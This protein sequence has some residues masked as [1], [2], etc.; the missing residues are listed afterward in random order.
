[1]KTLLS[2]LLAFSLA[3]VASAN[4]FI[5]DPITGKLV[6]VLGTPAG[7]GGGVSS[8]SGTLPIISSGGSTPAISCRTATGSV[9]GCL[10]E[11]DWTTFNGKQASGNYLTALTGDVSA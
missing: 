6:P 7:G 9:S 8:V 1:M 2:L 3:H 10:S 11:T 5:I 4:Q